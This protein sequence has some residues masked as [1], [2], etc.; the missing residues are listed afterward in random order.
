MRVEDKIDARWLCLNTPLE[1]ES[2][3][4]GDPINR[5]VQ[6]DALKDGQSTELHLTLRCQSPAMLKSDQSTIHQDIY[7][8]NVAIHCAPALKKGQIVTLEALV[9]MPHLSES[10]QLLTYPD[11]R[12]RKPTWTLLASAKVNGFTVRDEQTLNVID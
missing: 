3:R 11:L 6:I 12:G 2:Y 10:T 8:E 5:T 4:F 1:T 9:T 7:S